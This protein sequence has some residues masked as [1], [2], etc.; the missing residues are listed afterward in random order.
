MLDLPRGPLLVGVAD[1]PEALLRR[2]E[3]DRTARVVDLVEAR[4]D[5]FA[6]QSLDACA[7]A[8]ARL[9]ATGTPVLVTIRTVGQGGRFAGRDADRLA[10]FRA[11]L[12]VA[13]WADVEVDAG[14]AGDVA[15]L[16][17]GRTGGQ[18][19]VSH[20]D[21]ERTPP[22]E[23]LLATVDDCR[24]GAGAIAKVATAAKTD[25]DRRV[26]LDL[27]SRR[28]DRTCVIGMG[29]SDELRIELAA[30]G[31]LLA[32]GFLDDPTAPGQLSAEET[33]RRLLAACPPYARRK[34]L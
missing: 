23:A 9:E 14:I 15:V 34:A 22:L 4:V 21:F 1:R 6:T 11:A 25:A 18:L 28:P 32:Y 29:G 3:L 24:V 12:S 30:S 2:A 7:E 16:V 13:S 20:H 26:L 10:L 27:L 19:V 33:H 17:A 8:C 5:L 31:S